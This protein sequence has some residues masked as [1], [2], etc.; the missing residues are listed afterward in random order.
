MQPFS[1]RPTTTFPLFPVLLLFA[2]LLISGCGESEKVDEPIQSNADIVCA[3]DNGGI[4]LPEEVLK[5]SKDLK[6]RRTFPVH[7]AKFDLGGHP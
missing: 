4:T 6:A 5:A 1:K 7:S 2:M 3:P